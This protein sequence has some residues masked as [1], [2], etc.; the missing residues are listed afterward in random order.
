M[1]RNS[2]AQSTHWQMLN[3]VI[4]YSHTITRTHALALA[5][6]HNLSNQ[7]V[8]HL[9]ADRRIKAIITTFVWRF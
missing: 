7:M 4:S 3:I 2:I 8:S 1:K 9:I 6:V 5:L